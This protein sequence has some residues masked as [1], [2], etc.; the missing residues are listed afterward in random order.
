MM[1]A[2]RNDPELWGLFTRREEYD[3]PG[4]DGHGRFSHGLSRYREVTDP[5][6]SGFLLDHG[7]EVDYGDGKKF[8]V[9]LTHDIDSIYP[10]SREML[11]GSIGSL[12]KGGFRGG[13][14]IPFARWNKKWNP[15][16][17]F[18]ETMAVEE[19]YG[20]RS[21]FFFMATRRDPHNKVYCIDDLEGEMGNILDKGWE[22]GLHGGYYSYDSLDSVLD[23]KRSLERALGK[24]VTGY[25]N[26]FLRFKVPDTWRLLEKAGFEY[27][28]TLGY[29]DHV[30]FRNG[31]CHPFRP[32][33]LQK[34][35]WLGIAEIPLVVMADT[36]FNYMKMDH[37]RSWDTIKALVDTVE[38]RR[39]VMT[40]LWHNYQMGGE[41]LKLYEKILKYCREKGALL[42]GAE[43][44]CQLAPKK[45]T[46]PE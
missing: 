29:A 31:M 40:I 28:S 46:D 24:K 9:C 30:G 41:C 8:A 2:L 21:T 7:L 34:N 14:T 45:L 25:R 3:P 39:G 37:G 12:V 1:E 32:Y 16:W 27:D 11:N 22:I 6:V 36:L 33:D 44:I 5:R 35:R 23:E 17:N 42:T 4:L 38:K 20:A 19:K 43:N 10:T 18:R 13:F 15:L 26:H